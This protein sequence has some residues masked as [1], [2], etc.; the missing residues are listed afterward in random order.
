MKLLASLYL[1]FA[2]LILSAQTATTISLSVE[3]NDTNHIE[4]LTVTTYDDIVNLNVQQ[5]YAVK[6]NENQGTLKI[7]LIDLPLQKLGIQYKNTPLQLIVIKTGVENR[8]VLELTNSSLKIKNAK[9][10][11]G[12][13]TYKE[14]KILYEKFRRP[15]ARK[16]FVSFTKYTD[17]AFAYIKENNLGK[18]LH[19]GP[20][21]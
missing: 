3:A 5:Q 14:N 19:Y 8:I 20:I 13:E 9:T 18:E 7:A 16:R 21:R 1:F 4:Q 12:F 6:L 2:T 17:K 11:T 15:I 10:E